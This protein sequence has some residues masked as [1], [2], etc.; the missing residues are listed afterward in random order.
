VQQPPTFHRRDITLANWRIHPHTHFSFQHA[1]EFVPTAAI[2]VAAG[3][4]SPVV[5]PG[6]I[7]SLGVAHQGGRRGLLDHL[8]DTHADAFAILRDGVFLDEWHAPHFIPAR[9]SAARP[10]AISST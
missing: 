5:Q 4:E 8:A 3:S 9:P 10:C 1:G 7:A 2:T 6:L